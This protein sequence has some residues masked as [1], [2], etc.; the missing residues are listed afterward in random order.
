MGKI[1]NQLIDKMNEG[2]DDIDW[3]APIYDSAGFTESDREPAPIQSSSDG[4]K[5]W[6]VKSIK[7]DVEYKIWAPTYQEALKL[8]PMIESF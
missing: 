8:L 7:D 2:P 1:K 3:N 5:L 4:N 6:M